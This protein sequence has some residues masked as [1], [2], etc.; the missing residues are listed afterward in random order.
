MG[1]LLSVN[2]THEVLSG[3]WAGSVGETGIDKRPVEGSVRL[4]DH[5]VDGDR[6]LD[7]QHHGGV[8]KAVYA[9]A[10]EDAAVWSTRTDFPIGPGSFGENLTTSG[11]DCTNAVIGERWRIGDAVLQVRQPRIPCSVFAGFWG[12]PRLVKT[13]TDEGRPGVYMSIETEG[14][15]RAGDS[16]EVVSRPDHGVTVGMVFRAKSGDRELV[17]VILA[18][19]E[20]PPELREWAMKLS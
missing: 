3:E 7:T 14:S 18:A 1:M 16:I 12:E 20:L 4:F 19:P 17:P 5:H 15:V 13:F 8:F 11:I 10:S 2:I 6:V 9:Y